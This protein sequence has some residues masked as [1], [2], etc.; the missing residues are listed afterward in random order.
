M[1][2][3]MGWGQ[4]A[5]KTQAEKIDELMA[6]IQQGGSLGIEMEKSFE[7]LPDKFVVLLETS[8][9]QYDLI[10]ANLVKNFQKK[11][12]T[13]IFVT[14]NK[15]GEDLVGMLQKSG[16]DRKGLF[17]I[18]AISKKIAK[19]VQGQNI[20]YV[21]SPQ[22]LIEI[23]AVITDYAE[24]LPQ[25]KGF[26]II[27]SLSTLLVYNAEKTVEKFVHLLGEKMRAMG[28]KSIFTIRSNTKP[29][30]MDVLT[31]FCDKVINMG[32]KINP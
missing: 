13:G 20:S 19:P 9:A 1:A 18:D 25:G 14:L 6:Y 16:I 26:L 10:I 29:E 30:T 17:I 21:D 24:D 3:Q 22:N 5:K 8:T 2:M 28:M 4:P 7:E 11:G 15:S 31:Q 32:S 27:D 12:F 23:E